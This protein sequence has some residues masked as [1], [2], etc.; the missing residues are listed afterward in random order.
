[1]KPAAFLEGLQE[2]EAT[3]KEAEGVR[4]GNSDPLGRRRRPWSRGCVQVDTHGV[5]FAIGR[6]RASEPTS[7][8]DTHK[9]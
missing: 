3:P 5:Q 2:L 8:T 1:M 7:R 6:A 9:G 4:K